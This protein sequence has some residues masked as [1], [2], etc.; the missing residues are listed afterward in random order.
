MPKTLVLYKIGDHSRPASSQDILDFQSKLEE[1]FQ[2]DKP[3]IHLVTNHTVQVEVHTI[4]DSDPDPEDNWIEM[5][6]EFH[7]F[8]DESSDEDAVEYVVDFDKI[9]QSN[10]C[11]NDGSFDYVVNFDNLNG[12]PEK[13]N[14]PSIEDE[15]PEVT[16][17]G[18]LLEFIEKIR[19]GE[20]AAYLHSSPDSDTNNATSLQYGTWEEEDPHIDP[21]IGTRIM[22]EY[23]GN[24]WTEVLWDNLPED[25]GCA[26]GSGMPSFGKTPYGSGKEL[27]NAMAEHD[28]PGEFIPT[29]SPKMLRLGFV[30]S[31]CAELFEVPLRYYKIGL[32]TVARAAMQL[33][34][35]R[36]ALAASRGA[37]GPE[38]FNDSDEGEDD[39]FTVVD[40]K[41]ESC[42]G[43]N[44]DTYESGESVLN[45]LK[46]HN[47]SPGKKTII[48][49]DN[50]RKLRL[51]WVCCGCAKSFEVKIKDARIGLRDAALEAMETPDG[52]NA[53]ASAVAHHPLT[54]GVAEFEGEVTEGCDRVNCGCTCGCACG[55]SN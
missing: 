37:L 6:R 9:R 17:G 31:E 26:C 36:I 25:A 39:A 15:F 4:P 40:N 5:E 41:C 49:S 47:C 29:D 32:N 51:G 10:N 3:T 50:P 46:E 13:A 52:R 27:L 14:E 7:S 43:E 24:G 21:P 34:S 54:H 28:C 20:I 22:I 53:L 1:A 19:S 45:A 42:G 30:C 48:C 55:C 23:T 44:E 38:H 18:D 12:E 8:L 35:G 16:I 2:D 33:S 11:E